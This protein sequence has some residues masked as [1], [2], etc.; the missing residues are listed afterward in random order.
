MIEHLIFSRKSWYN[1]KPPS[2]SKHSVEAKVETWISG[3]QESDV[4]ASRLGRHVICKGQFFRSL[5]SLEFAAPTPRGGDMCIFRG[6]WGQLAMGWTGKRPEL[7]K[8]IE[9]S[10]EG[11]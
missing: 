7:M 8:K 1:L 10:F 3:S 6:T 9:F 4:S 2:L 11:A 5:R